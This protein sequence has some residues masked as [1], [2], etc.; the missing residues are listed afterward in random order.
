MPPAARQGDGET[1]MTMLS[2]EARQDLQGIITT[3]YGHLRHAAFLFVRFEDQVS[4]KGW[5]RGILPTLTT[6]EPWEKDALGR[7]RRPDSTLNL[8]LTCQGLQTFGL[9]EETVASFPTEFVLGMPSRAD[10]LGDTG[11]DAP[12]AWEL[13]GPGNTGLHGVL[14]IYGDS[15][16]TVDKR[17]TALRKSFEESGGIVQVS[18]QRGTRTERGTEPFG[19][20]A[21]GLSQPRIE[22]VRHVDVPGRWV[23]RTGEF[24]LGYLNELGLY[25]PSPAVSMAH[26]PKKILPPFPEG[27]LPECRDFGRNGTFLVY[28]KLIQ[29]VS[30]F[31]RFIQQQTEGPGDRDAWR[32]RILILASKFMGRWPSGAPLVLAPNRDDPE[33][34]IRNDFL[35][36]PSDQDGLACPIGAHIRRANPRDS[37][38]RVRDTADESIRTSNQHRIIRR[39][40]PFGRHLFPDRELDQG[41]GPMDLKD[42]GN[43]RG[44]H[45]FAVNADNKRQFEFVQQT[46]LNNPKFNGLY[47]DKDPVVGDNDGTTGMTIPRTPLRRTISGIPRFV[48]V[49]AGAYFFLPS[50]SA[51]RF[52]AD[53]T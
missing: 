14:L 16:D 22:G 35:Y 50:V 32:H 33:L 11:D 24:I 47:D 34:A 36:R 9:P 10:V 41:D 6:A 12:K 5:L 38:L 19:F 43:S 20:N 37:L 8:A 7:K 53:E 29:D 49:K 26:D 2:D 46:W 27:A 17:L 1:A 15:E 48:H 45:F 30:G 44:L 25:P 21:D 3:G 40:V 13:G 31:W 23:I 18:V 42:D 52:L 51:L 4:A 28:R 39:G